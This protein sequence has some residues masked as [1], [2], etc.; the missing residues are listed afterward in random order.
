MSE[1][2]CKNNRGSNGCQETVVDGGEEDSG[3]C[4]K[5]YWPGIAEANK[6]YEEL[7]VQGHSRIQ[8]AELSGLNDGERHH[9]YGTTMIDTP[10][11]DGNN[12]EEAAEA[13]INDRLLN[14]IDEDEDGT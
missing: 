7:L 13:E 14:E 4:E 8:A 11:Q 12:P 9:K 10:E 3:Y 5:C 1:G 2:L 6:Q